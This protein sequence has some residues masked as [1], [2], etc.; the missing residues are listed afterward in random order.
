MASWVQ[1]D[2]PCP[3]RVLPEI[4]EEI[5]Q[6]S[7]TLLTELEQMDAEVVLLGRLGS[8]A[9]QER[10]VRKVGPWNYTHAGLA[11]RDHPQGA[12]TLV[13]LVHRCAQYSEI[14]TESL[15]D[16]L[17]DQLYRLDLVMAV[18]SPAL[19]S[20]LADLILHQDL[21]LALH[22]PQGY[23]QVSSPYSI[24]FQN[25]NEYV[26]DTLVMAL[27]HQAGYR[28]QTRTESK[29]Y[30]NL[31]GLAKVFE[32]EEVAISVWENLGSHLGLGPDNATV[33]D[34]T[35]RE[36]KSNRLQMVSVGSLIR[37][38]EQMHALESIKE[39]SAA[40]QQN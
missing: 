34:H 22:H 7:Q 25:S 35:W 5:R 37:F 23:S 30:F 6:F 9:P 36:R 31:S 40:H 1:A 19:Q 28:P 24:D 38:L 27:A 17:N 33:K 2:T 13:H 20:V 11:Y 4:T 39:I 14:V 3:A 32:P 26:L 21:A 29:T 18:P 10:F 12:W 15:Q 8:A 16:F